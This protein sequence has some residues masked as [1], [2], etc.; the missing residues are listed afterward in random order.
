MAMVSAIR[1]REAICEAAF[2]SLSFGFLVF[3]VWAK[4]TGVSTAGCL[5]F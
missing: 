3:Y 5:Q 4:I 2:L 1:L